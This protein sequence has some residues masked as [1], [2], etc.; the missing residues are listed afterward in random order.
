[1][2]KQFEV[3][4]EYAFTPDYSD[5]RYYFKAVCINRT[6]KFVEFYCPTSRGQ[7]ILATEAV[8]HHYR[9]KI[10]QS[11]TCEYVVKGHWICTA[12]ESFEYV[13]SLAR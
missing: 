6:P 10:R 11:E 2:F 5:R 12:N 13:K 3:G 7:L 8:K 4:Q 9:L 1:M